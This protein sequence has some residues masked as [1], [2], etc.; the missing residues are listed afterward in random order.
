L[1][2]RIAFDTNRYV[3]LCKGVVDT[4]TLLAEAELVVLPFIVRI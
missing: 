1:E 4:V 3:D 2:V